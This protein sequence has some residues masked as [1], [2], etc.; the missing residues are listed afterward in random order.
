[1]FHETCRTV[2]RRLWPFLHHYVLY[3]P[4]TYSRVWF[5]QAIH[6]KCEICRHCG[7]AID[8][9]KQIVSCPGWWPPRH[10]CLRHEL[11]A[12]GGA[13]KTLILKIT[14]LNNPCKNPHVFPCFIRL[15]HIISKEIF[16]SPIRIFT[17]LV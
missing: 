7:E 3:H 9:G 17:V 4:V 1:V 8:G 5:D 2:G 12:Q 6:H 16:I 11:R 14:N 13:S 10:F 15:K